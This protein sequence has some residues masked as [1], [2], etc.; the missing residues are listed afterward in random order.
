MQEYLDLNHMELV[1]MEKIDKSDVYYLPHSAVFHNNKIRI[2]FN[3]S[4]KSYNGLALNDTLY[5]GQKLQQDIISVITRWR[6]YKVVFTCDIVKMF[7]QIIIHADDR[8]WLRIVYDFG[9]GLQHYRLNTVTYGTSPASYQSLRVLRKIIE[10]QCPDNEKMKELFFQLSYVD[11]F[12]GGADDSETASLIKYELV[13]LLLKAQIKLY[14]WATNDKNLLTRLID[15]V[16]SEKCVEIPDAVSALGLRWSPTPDKF[17]FKI[18][19][20]ENRDNITKRSILSDS[21]KFFDPLGW[22]AP[23]LI[24][25]KMFYQDLWIDGL[26][27]DTPLTKELI[28]K[29]NIIK[30]QIHELEKISIPRWFGGVADTPWALHDFA[31]ASK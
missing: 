15:P 8:D 9:Y 25:L 13:K 5:V 27:W 28:N 19:P 14:T 3:A 7:R 4:M 6:F 30:D 11:D 29:W 31:D 23:T 24:K 26:E 16:Q 1:P 17:S 21:S 10:D 20:I 18:Q 12:F 2:V 22:L